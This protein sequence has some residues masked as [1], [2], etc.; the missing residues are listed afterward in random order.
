[1]R[2]VTVPNTSLHVSAL[3]LGTGELGAWIT[4]RDSERL[5]EEFLKLGGNFVDTAHCYA[6]WLPAGAGCSER[7]L[8]RVVRTLG[9]RDQLVIA[10]KGGHP[11]GGEAYPRPDRYMEPELV[12]RDLMESLERLEM[13][14]VDLYYLHRDDPRVPVDEIID[15]LNGHIRAGWVRAI[16][17]SNWSTARIEQANRY[18]S[19]HGLHG[20]VISQ[21]Q[22]SLAIPNW[23]V[24]ADP[25]TRYVT[26]EDADWYARHAIPICAYTATAL[27][28][29]AGSA[30]GEQSFHNP[31][32]AQRRE[33]AIHLAQQLGVTATQV[34][35]AW[36]LH[37]KPVTIPIFGTTNL[38]HLR[39]CMRSAEIVLTPEQVHW[40][41]HGDRSCASS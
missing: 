39:E 30:K 12:S 6:F 23:Q 5:L 38:E 32:N 7:E 36:L 10:T 18:A 41:A 14:M 15:A 31:V 26:E 16:G 35:L 25:T 34:A 24:T 17:A 9:V 20:F 28:Y 2:T 29:F 27:G 22:W 40:L 8:G 13:E 19:E 3:C 11:S 33:R 37:Q 21:V 4:G 1:M